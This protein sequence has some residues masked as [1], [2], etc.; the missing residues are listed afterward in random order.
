[1]KLL[2]VITSLRTGGA[3]KLM[4]DL[5]PKLHGFGNDVELFLFDGVRT[6]FME[7]LEDYG[8]KIHIARVKGSVY[9]PRIVLR[10]RHFLNNYDVVHT[11]NTAPQFFAV[12][13]KI[14]TF[15][16]KVK[17][18]T[19]E[20]NTTNR[21]RDKRFF[22][23]LDRWMYS[24]YSKVICISNQAET[25][26]R[27]Y[28][29]DHSSKIITIFNGIDFSKFSNNNNVN[30]SKQGNEKSFVVTMVAAFREQKD[31]QTL[32]KAFSLLPANFKLQLVGN[33]DTELIEMC[34]DLVKQHELTNRVD[35]MGMRTD[36]PAI[37]HASDV[38]VLSSHYEGLSLSSLEG[39]ASGRPFIASDVEGLHEIVNGYGLLF[40]HEDAHDLAA[41]IIELS[42]DRAYAEQIAVK[43]QERAK[44]F[45]I[46][47]MAENYNNIYKELYESRTLKF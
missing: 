31:Q 27:Q 16:S 18:V 20:H 33:G 28:L 6:E 32:I 4:V 24:K 30:D 2:H 35:F 46:G 19:T 22:V 25:N 21:R 1:M 26:L 40:P 15:R 34:K 11:H 42:R 38:I 8:I 37:L 5:L 23:I 43:C 36:I 10:L 13:A 9:D 45:D 39:M 3:E 14:L 47:I 29:D 44:Q 7:Q 12:V 17:L 41:K